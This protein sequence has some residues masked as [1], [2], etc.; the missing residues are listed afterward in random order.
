[1]S[2][3][4]HTQRQR[5]PHLVLVGMISMAALA[6]ACGS[7]ESETAPSPGSAPE[8]SGAAPASDTTPAV[9]SDSLPADYPSDLPAYPGAVPGKALGIPGTAML[10]TFETQDPASDVVA[11]LARELDEQGWKVN[12]EGGRLEASK[13][14]RTANFRFDPSAR[15]GTTIS[16]SIA[17]G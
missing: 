5:R 4:I 9:L 2:R 15:G 8:A 3:T 10:V 17:G 6:T 12:E 11:Y 14:A 1:M 7:G 16:V 13:D